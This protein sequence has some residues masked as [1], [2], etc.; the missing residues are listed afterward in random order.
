[1]KVYIAAP[2]FNKF[3]IDIVDTIVDCLR[4]DNVEFFSPKDECLYKE[5][6]NVLDILNQNLSAIK[7][8]NAIIVVTD[9]KD[10]GT[11]FEAGYA[12]SIGVPILYIWLGHTP[13]LKFNLMLSASAAAVINNFEDLRKQI[14]HF[15]DCNA[16][17]KSI[18]IMEFN[19]E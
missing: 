18:G 11:M 12:Y 16:F 2:F 15:Q 1:M 17:N 3:Q 8:S 19:H 10:V 9:F 4:E 5:G 13:D 14:K 7:Q 6:D